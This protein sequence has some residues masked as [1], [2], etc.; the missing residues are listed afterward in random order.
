MSQAA[1]LADGQAV[2]REAFYAMACDPQRS[3]VVEA[4]AGAGK[5]WMLVSRI[6]R[7]LLEG[8]AAH[9]V[10]A[11]TFTRKAAA[12]MRER[13]VAWLRGFASHASTHDERVQAL[14]DRGLSSADAE[15]LAP[16]LATLHARLLAS[17]RQVE[18]RTF[19]AWFSQLLQ[20]APIEL[21]DELGLPAD[22]S[23]IEDLD[24]HRDEVF[25]RFHQAVQ[26][27]AD[28]RDDY[29]A[30]VVAH[31]RSQLRKWLEAAWARRVEIELADAHGSLD[32]SVPAP[33]LEGASQHPADALQT[34]VWRDALLGLAKQLGA[35]AKLSQKAAEALLQ[36]LEATDG[37]ACFEQVWQALFTQKN[38]PRQLNKKL[39]ELQQ[40]Q[41]ELEVIALQV[42][43]FNDHL[44]HQRM[45]RLARRLLREFAS[46]KRERGLADMADLELGGLALLRDSSLAGWVQER[47][48][49][50]IRH[51]L[52][53]EFQDTSPLQWQALHV[54]LA[55]YAGAGG[56]ASGQ[57]GPGVFVVGDPKQS[58]YRFRRA[59]PRVFMAMQAFVVDALGGHRLACD[60]TRRNAP[61]VLTAI[62]AVFEEAQTAQA[63][64]GFRRHTTE[65]FL[66]AEAGV[67]QLPR[68]VKAHA[69]DEAKSV[70]S[71]SPVVWRDSLTTPRLSAE[72]E[73]RKAEAMQ[74]AQAIER[75]VLHEGVQPREIFVLSRKRQSLRMAAE[76]LRE[77]GVPYAAPED[78]ALM[79]AP[80]ARDL[81][82]LLDAITSPQ[83]RLSLAHALRSPIF[84]VGDDDLIALAQQARGGDWWQALLQPQTA[85]NPAMARASH[86]LQRWRQASFGLPPHDLLDRIVAEGEVRQRM[87]AT[88]PAAQRNA[89]LAAID[90]VLAQALTLDSARFATPYG[91]V[92]ALK[93]RNVKSA[94]PAAANAVQ[95]L[96]VHGA[97]GLEARIVFVMDAEPEPKKAETA[98]VLIDWQ[99]D[100]PAPRLCA[101]VYSESSAPPSAADALAAEHAAQEREE[102][103]GLYVAM[104]RARERLVFSATEPSRPSPRMSWLARV[105]PYALPM[106]LPDETAGLGAAEPCSTP[107][108]EPP[109]LSLSVLPTW[110]GHANERMADETD[111][112]TATGLGKAVHRALQWMAELAVDD[113]EA[114]GQAAASAA[115]AEFGVSASATFEIARTILQSPACAR[116]FHGTA[117]RWSRNEVAIGG[118]GQTLRIDRLVCLADPQGDVWWVLDYKLQHAPEALVANRAQLLRYR[119]VVQRA[120]P[121][122]RVRCAFITGR[123]ELIEVD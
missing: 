34:P 82:A 54:W 15:R 29:L 27:D 62:N 35:G 68:V 47:L 13:L 32:A 75:L 21:L 73:R 23:L 80:E 98:S 113:A 30:M 39:L 107:Q 111:D 85:L 50:R 46:Y 105:A 7:A 101:F 53:D 102:L 72:V 61:E 42:R 56:G 77:H 4:C 44:E 86:L 114:S 121:R 41:A 25:R 16:S 87:A 48:D 122:E 93:R 2:T 123:G 91:F 17:G 57:R 110:R 31:G 100:D 37:P 49:L 11:I 1:Y 74:V 115:A 70:A 38:E 51:L 63:F 118:D 59:E 79:Q 95:L 83:H 52:I 36:A 20:A 33:L 108:T 76:A 22:M 109:R 64:A 43:Q 66:N 6:V 94:M 55:S 26:A 65:A 40:V 81:L 9:E 71:E 112:T 92:R 88:V 19:H 116:F 10:L 84:G 60:H 58:I 106:L 89:A 117:I 119:A 120:Q 69:D 5:T 97:K 8:A 24:D 3:V 28:L 78:T 67:W 96:T 104:S 99:V 90:A 12:E 103:N 14:R 45:T 18:I